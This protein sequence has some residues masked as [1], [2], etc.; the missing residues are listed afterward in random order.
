MNAFRNLLLIAALPLVAQAAGPKLV[1]AADVA[2][3]PH[4]FIKGAFLA[5]QS[6]DPGAG[7]SVLLM[8]FPKG[9]TIPAHTHTAQETVTL[10]SGSGLFG[11]GETVEAAKGAALGRGSFI[12]IPGGAPHWAIAQEELVIS[13]V[14]DRA[15][16]FH[17]CGG[18]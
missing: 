13:V 5:V 4:P 16:D 18:K 6:G 11:G 14:M 17:A 2:W 7:P 10:V 15:A 3:G 1:K 9:M 8:K 12:T